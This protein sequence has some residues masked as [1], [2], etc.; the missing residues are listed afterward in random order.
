MTE[1]Y[2]YWRD[3]GISNG[4]HAT[5]KD[6]PSSFG[7]GW[8]IYHYGSPNHFITCEIN[9]LGDPVSTMEKYYADQTWE[10]PENN[11]SLHLINS[12]LFKA[13]PVVWGQVHLIVRN[14]NLADP[15]IFSGTGTY[16]IYNS[17]IDHFAAYGGTKAYLENCRV[18]ADIEVKDYNTM[19][20]GYH[21]VKKD[22]N[23]FSIIE[24]NGGRYQVLSTPG[25]PWPYVYL[26]ATSLSIPSENTTTTVDI[27]SNSSWFLAGDQ[28]WLTVSPV[29]GT[30]H[31]TV[32]ITAQAN[33]TVLPRTAIVTATLPGISVQQLT[34]I[35]A[36]GTS[37][38][39]EL[40][41]NSLSVFPN[42]VI[43]ELTI[44]NAE[45]NSE[46]ILSDF[47]GRILFKEFATSTRVTIDLS[48]LDDGVYLLR[49][50]SP[51]SSRTLK[52]V[53]K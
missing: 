12:T 36:A 8:A 3:L 10:I 19:V 34:I 41:T 16:E 26:S 53:K 9:D 7:I 38:I 44:R 50:T 32:T 23:D 46:I 15:R 25:I 5:V 47:S 21:V 51:N 17:T 45:V 4:T 40:D 11:S 49:A 28:S 35:Q 31:S 13:W 48:L 14:S 22:S 6:T 42:P 18:S 37:G 30:N 29:S 1:S 27:K 20:Y 33:P 24:V 39:N 52:I 2:L 43:N